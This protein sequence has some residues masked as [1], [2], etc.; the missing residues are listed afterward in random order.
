M[1]LGMS[2]IQNALELHQQGIF[3]TSLN[4]I[5]NKWHNPNHGSMI[6][7]ALAPCQC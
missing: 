6:R 2:A 4:D 5:I 7:I 1:G 3:S